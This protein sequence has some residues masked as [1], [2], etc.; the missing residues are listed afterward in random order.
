MT[1]E[2]VRGDNTL[3]GRLRLVVSEIS[4]VHPVERSLAHADHVLLAEA[5]PAVLARQQKAALVAQ[6]RAAV[7]VTGGQQERHWKHD[8]RAVVGQE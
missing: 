1:D 7:A 5:A 4:H 6:L 3:D 2:F 8:H